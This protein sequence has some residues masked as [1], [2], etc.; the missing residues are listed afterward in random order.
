MLRYTTKLL[1]LVWSLLALPPAWAQAPENFFTGLNPSL[2]L[3]ADCYTLLY[4][5]Y[6][7]T[8]VQYEFNAS[9][10]FRRLMLVGDIGGGYIERKGIQKDNQAIQNICKNEGRY[11]RIGF[12]YNFLPRNSD[13]NVAFLGLRYA[14]G[15]SEDLLMQRRLPT[16]YYMSQ[17]PNLQ[18][19]WFEIVAGVSVKVLDLLYIGCTIGY[20]FAKK[21]KT[22]TSHM[23]FDIMGWGMN[24]KDS[25]IGVNYYITF[26]I[27][28]QQGEI[29]VRRPRKGQ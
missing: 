24:E 22:P 16:Q 1:I 9:I 2:R 7:G 10:D 12:N 17:E 5:I 13:Y 25:N 20:K 18:A 27:P 23:P 4:H 15:Y 6:Q 21:L 3:G 8:G 11:F 26:R 19:R 29:N 14:R 28:L